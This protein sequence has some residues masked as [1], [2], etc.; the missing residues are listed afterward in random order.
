MLNEL[1]LGNYLVIKYWDTRVFII[2]PEAKKNPAGS[3]DDLLKTGSEIVAT[4]NNNDYVG[5]CP[6]NIP[7]GNFLLDVDFPKVG[8]EA[9]MLKV[10][11]IKFLK[12]YLCNIENRDSLK[13]IQNTPSGLHLFCEVDLPVENKT[14]YSNL[15]VFFEVFSNKLNKNSNLTVIGK[16]YG[17]LE[18]KLF[19]NDV[20]TIF[21]I[22]S[23]KTNEINKRIGTLFLSKENI[24]SSV[25]E[26]GSPI[27]PS[28]K[29]RK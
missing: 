4:I 13:I 1:N 22:Y 19:I 6:K 17:L 16:E 27:P 7:D 21:N 3:V 2:K 9:K 18:K 24:I 15:G 26:I 29:R 11:F 14:I 8:V 28:Y 5:L 12:D 20:R 25:I 10:N 23:E